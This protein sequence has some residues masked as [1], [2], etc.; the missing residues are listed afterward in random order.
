MPV[1]ER[2]EEVMGDTSDKKDSVKVRENL[3]LKLDIW[4][5]TER[6]NLLSVQQGAKIIDA[7]NDAKKNLRTNASP[8][9]IL[10]QMLLNI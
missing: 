8:R 7:I 10:E 6:K 3:L 2:M 1:H 4:L 9:L 5:M